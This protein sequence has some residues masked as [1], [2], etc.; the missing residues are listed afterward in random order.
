MLNDLNK[1]VL[2]R[3]ND[4]LALMFL[5]MKIKPIK[6]DE[7]EKV[8]KRNVLGITAD[9]KTRK[10]EKYGY[11]T[12]ILYFAPSNISGLELCP[13]KSKGCVSAWSVYG[14]DGRAWRPSSL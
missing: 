2:K 3:A 5:K 8:Y 11:L 9:I 14:I 12:G 6:L 10:G 7:I 4:N 13:K 1:A